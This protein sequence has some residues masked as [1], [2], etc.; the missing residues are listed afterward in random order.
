FPA[1]QAG[2]MSAV[3]AITGGSAPA[4]GGSSA[5]GRALAGLPLPRPLTLGLGNA[6]ARP[7]RA[8][9]TLGSI[10]LGVAT[11]VF[12]LTMH[13]SLGQ[14]AE[15]IFRD[16]F[17]AVQAQRPLP[18]P[19]GGIIQKRGPAPAGPSIGDAQVVA[20]LQADPGTA[21]FV[22][23]GEADTTVPGIADPVTF[24][25]YRGDSSWIGYQL[26]AGRWFAGPGEVVAPTLLLRQ[27]HL[28]VGDS[29]S[30]Q[31]HGHALP[32]RVVGEILDQ[33]AGD[34]LLRGDWATLAGVDPGAEAA[35]YEIALQTGV[36]P[37]QYA[38][39][40]QGQDPTGG[41][42]VGPQPQAGQSV[43]FLL[44]S[45][46]IAGLALVLAAIAVAGVFNTVVLDTREQVRDIA[47]L[48][49]VGMSPNQVV[50]MVVAAVAV[51]GLL[52]GGL[53]I[54]LGLFLQRNIL[55]LMAEIATGTRLPASFYDPLSPLLLPLLALAGVAVAAL[56]AWLPARW[57]AY[58]GVTEVLQTE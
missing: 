44:I 33:T 48:K 7:L 39:R 24:Y 2:R 29:F 20:L 41:L 12:A 30:A 4:A 49:A 42:Y 15:G 45:A 1:W 17:V 31:I 18:Q 14:V 9:L 6:T 47:I 58:A 35:R 26:I 50:S 32:L 10:L 28:Q 37:E 52:A 40:I 19:S 51:L 5:L 23:I 53:G 46:V 8:A 13:D 34:L 16:Q 11:V 25:T 43:P 56:G 21:R 22:S 27:A 36:G 38:R 54:P 3:G 55:A 57:A